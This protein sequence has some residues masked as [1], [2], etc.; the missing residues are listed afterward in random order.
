MQTF[1]IT[2]RALLSTSVA[3]A[4]VGWPVA[5]LMAA[6][7]RDAKN[8]PWD[9][10]VPLGTMPP[11]FA[12]ADPSLRALNDGWRFHEGDIAVPEVRGNDD[13]YS[14]TKTGNAQGAAGVDYDDSDWAEVRV[15]HDW[16]IAHP[17]EEDQNNAFAYRRRGIGWYRRYVTLPADWC[18]N[19]LELQIGAVTG[20]ATIWFNG[21]VVAHSFSGYVQQNIDLTPF[22]RFGDEPNTIAIR[23][24]ADVM[25]GW[26]YEGA[27]I[28]RDCWLAVRPKLHI[29]TDGVHATPRAGEKDG[30]QVPVSVTLNHAGEGMARGTVTAE[31]RDASGKTVAQGS[32]DAEVTAL[33]SAEVAV[34]LAV[35]APDLWSPDR[36]TLYSLLT[37]LIIE[38]KTVETRRTDIGFRTTRFD[39]EEGFFL[40]GEAMKIKG[41]CIH[42]DHAGV[43]VAVPKALGDWRLR[44]LKQIGINA[45][46]FT[47]APPSAEMLDGCDRLGIMV[48]AE[49][50]HFNPSPDYIAQLEWMVRRDRNRPSIILWSVLNEEPMQG[51]AQ[52]YEMVRRLA[53]A[54]RR[55]DDT[56]PVTAAMNDGFFTAKNGADAVDVVG[57]NYKAEWY[58]RYHALH[59]DRPLISTEDTSAVM[60]RGEWVTDKARNVLTSYDTEAP[61]WGLTHEQSWKMIGSR[62]FIASTFVWTGFDYHGEPTPL[63]WPAATSSFGILDLCGFGK[64]AYHL[65]R[66]QWI[67]D[68]PVIGVSPHWTW[69]GREGQTIKV[70]VPANTDEV[71]LLLNGKMIGRQ[72]RVP[73]QVPQ[74]QVP[75]APGRL[76]A[77]GF[78]QGREVV[79]SV[80]ETT[81]AAAS[82]RLTPDRPMML[83]DGL[84]VQPISID[85]LDRA[86]RHLPT[87]TDPVTFS[88]E[89]GEIIGV[90]NGDPNDH[91]SEQA[92]ARRLFA[93]YAQVLVRSAKD[94]K[95]L[96]LTARVKGLADATLVLRLAKADAQPTIASLPHVHHVTEW[97]RTALL[98]DAPDGRTIYPD[99]AWRALS[100]VRTGRLEEPAASHGYFLIQGHF[101]ARRDVASRGGTLHLAGVT[102]RGE[103]WVDGVR[104]ATKSNAAPAPIS[105]PI[106]A[107]AGQRVV[108][109]ILKADA[110]EAVGLNA[111]AAIW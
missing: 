4:A 25:E 5:D 19:Y 72:K 76:E 12:P 32:A 35:A 47:H 37:R 33:S 27:G 84:D 83:A 3:G 9:M 98:K 96:V 104:V 70:M 66:A 1:S 94:A 30:W 97:R 85:L 36:P 21:I 40:N 59:P 74:W 55:L 34:P 53:D 52:G 63:P 60:T 16:A 65:R 20:N 87:A 108:T 50:R 79:R 18:D 99:K 17:I 46:R 88:I 86:G 64:F 77:V 89:G 93:G 57:F 107:E 92:A 23:V 78:N 102:G 95:R 109:I 15:P 14:A 100:Y 58:D 68:R 44:R 82:I 103:I 73:F 67:A 61:E 69:P 111:A 6:A 11:V 80:V 42:Q 22:A 43:G 13:T 105:V 81:G 71:A 41:V 2:R 90:G 24:D 51:N 49:N 110:G 54:A 29:A 38:G 75:Y 28:Y 45:I 10:P 8:L 31:L 48:M 62:P 39:A 56:R 106:P 7:R 101:E 26:W 91:D